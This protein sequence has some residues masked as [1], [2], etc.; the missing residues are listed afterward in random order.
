MTPRIKSVKTLKDYILEVDFDN[1]EKG[2]MGMMIS[3]YRE[4]QFMSMEKYCLW[5][6]L[7]RVQKR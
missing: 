1:G 4:M 2:M 3:T 6:K 5:Y 7:L